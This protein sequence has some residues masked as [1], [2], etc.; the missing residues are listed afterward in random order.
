MPTLQT[1]AN[2]AHEQAVADRLARAWR[3]RVYSMGAYAPIDWYFERSN[4]VVAVAELKIRSHPWGQYPSVYLSHDKWC[5]LMH[6]H[7]H[8]R[9]AALF[10]VQAADYLMYARIEDV[11]AHP[12]VMRGRVPPRPEAPH[13]RAPILEVPCG[14]FHRVEED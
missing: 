2:A 8:S 10:V 12:V 3:A 6:A 13:D 11:P 5:H 4:R 7:E 9:L 14:V 1:P